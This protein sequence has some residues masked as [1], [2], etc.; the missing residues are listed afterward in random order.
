MKHRFKKTV[1]S[2]AVLLALAGS[3]AAHAAEGDAVGSPFQVNTNTAGDQVAHWTVGDVAMDA[4]GDFVAVW[5][6]YYGHDGDGDGVYMRRFGANGTARDASDRLV[7]TAT[8][9]SQQAYGVDAAPDGRFVVLFRDS[10]TSP[11]NLYARLYDADGTAQGDPI[12]VNTGSTNN[13]YAGVAMAAD[14]SFV[15][16]WGTEAFE[17]VVV[18]RRFGADGAALDVAEVTVS[19]T[20]PFLL[21]GVEIGI[22]PA[23]NYTIVWGMREDAGDYNVRARRYSADGTAI[24]SADFVV[25]TTTAGSQDWPGIAV[26]PSGNVVVAWF[27]ETSDTGIYAKCFNAAGDVLKDEFPVMLD[28]DFTSSFLGIPYV[29]MDADGDFAI[30]AIDYGTSDGDGY[31]TYMQRFD[32]SCNKDGAVVNVGG[33][34]GSDGAG[35]I[36]MDADGDAVVLFTNTDG[37]DGDGYGIFA[38]RYQGKGHTVDLGLVGS[39]DTDTLGGSLT[40]TFTVTNSG[41]GVALGLVLENTLPSGLAYSSFSSS[42]GWSCSESTGTVTCTLPSLASSA[43]S[44]IDISVDTSAVTGSTIE[45][46]ARVYSAVADANDTDNSDTVVTGDTSDTGDTGDTGDDTTTTASGG[47]GAFGWFG[48]LFALAGLS[49]GRKCYRQNGGGVPIPSTATGSGCS[50]GA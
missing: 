18:A 50:T 14:G 2:S 48:L 23:G 11:K 40:Y 42:D 39:G 21:Y 28:A 32:S 4:D 22:D 15:V 17:G 37:D 38:Q 27:E 12:Q 30:A 45:N 24:D 26:D 3:P 31:A 10:N 13:P 5:T 34:E 41:S 7:N 35:G 20:A 6:D 43:S 33:P 1:L 47:G 36:A 8:A 25:N 9:G 19:T 46:S 29:A 16:A 44:S 49:R